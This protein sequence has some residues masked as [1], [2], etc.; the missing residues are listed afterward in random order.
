M[1]ST[2][3]C[4]EDQVLRRASAKKRA[5]TRRGLMPL[6]IA[7]RNVRLFEREYI[8]HHDVELPRYIDRLTLA[9]HY[10]LAT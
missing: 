2:A 1:R 10:G 4:L 8:A 9:Q 7:L 6:N 3:N 5:V